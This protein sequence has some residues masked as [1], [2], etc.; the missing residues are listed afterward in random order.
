ME[1][2]VAISKN[3]IN[4]VDLKFKRYLYSK[5]N[6]NNRLISI[7]GARGVGKT[8][9]MLQHIKENKKGTGVLYVSAEHL[10]F[11]TT[12][13]LDF[14]DEF[15]KTGGELLCIDEIH[16]YP[17]WSKEIK[18]IYDSYPTLKVIFSGSSVLEINKGN[19]DLSRRVI[20]YELQGMSFREYLNFTLNKSIPAITIDDLLTHDPIQLETPLKYF[21][22]YLAAG[23]YPF[24]TEGDYAVR[25]QGIISKIIDVDLVK[26]IG[27]KTHTGNKLKR[28]LSIVAQNVPFKPNMTKLASLTEISPRLLPEYFDYMEKA[29]LIRMLNT[30]GKS[31]RVL[32]KADKLYLNNT[33]LNYAITAQPDMGTLR[34]TF[35][36]SQFPSSFH[37]ELPNGKGDFIVNNMTFEVRGKNKKQEQLKGIENAYLVKDN[38]EEG[39]G[40]VLPLWKFG[41]L[42]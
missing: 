10:Y 15:V 30:K 31:L 33:N 6:W 36:I 2:L 13:L 5:I 12:T 26:F 8:T 29:G 34:E 3:L 16:Q 9:L 14:A 19:A 17:N 25:L 37:L 24:F 40:N 7:T 27:L 35:F 1:V 18:V 42:Y 4:Q 23:H 41:F 32:G 39:F 20:P 28:L 11:S 38:I 21:Q 22:D